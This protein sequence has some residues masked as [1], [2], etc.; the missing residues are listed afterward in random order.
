[1]WSHTECNPRKSYLDNAE[2]S[3][4]HWDRIGNDHWLIDTGR[5]YGISVMHRP[6]SARY[7]IIMVRSIHWNDLR[8]TGC[9]RYIVIEGT[10]E[11]PQRNELD[12][13]IYTMKCRLYRV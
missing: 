7:S 2:W 3:G 10:E 11:W 5:G 12:N 8:T 4:K 9:P 13:A 1:M 6:D